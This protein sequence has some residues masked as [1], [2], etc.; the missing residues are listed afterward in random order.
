LKT[1]SQQKTIRRLLGILEGSF[2]KRAYLLQVLL[3]IGVVFESIG[4]GMIIPLVNVITDADTSKDNTFIR[5]IRSVTG[6]ISGQQLVFITLAGFVLF[7]LVKTIFLSFL[8]WKQTEFTQSLSRNISDRLFKG[9]IHQ[10]YVFF[11]DKNSGVLMKNI[12]A[13]VSSL[14]GY[15]Q[16]FMQLQTELSVLIG[17]VVT[18]FFLEP[19]GALVV[20]AFVGGISFLLVRVTKRR[21]TTWGKSRQQYDARRS[22][23]LLQGLTGVSELK[24]FRKENFFISRYTEANKYYY[25]LQRKSQFMQQVQRF[26]LEFI[27]IFSIVV[28]CFAIMLRGESIG[29]L[30]PSLSLFLFASLRMLP[31]ANRII[32]NL[33]AMRFTKA[34][35]DLVYEEFQTFSSENKAAGIEQN[36]A[37]TIRDSIQLDNISYIYP[38]GTKKALDSISFRIQAGSV[39]GIIGQSG[40]GKTTLVN[41]IVGLL[42]PS[43]G[44]LSIDG[45]DITDASHRL[46]KLTGYVPQN[47]FLLDDTLKR[48]IAF[49]IP[50]ELIDDERLLEVIEAAQLRQVVEGMEGGVEGVVGE[51][52]LKLS[53]GQRQ[54]IGIARALYH[55][56]ELLI[57]DEGTSALDAETESYIMESVA[58]LKGRLTILLIA[59]R[60]STL[61]ICDIVYKMQDGKIMAEG[62]LEEIVNI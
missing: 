23:S 33:Q 56:P 37:K 14:T 8:V 25:E 1:E 10:P 2:K 48:N 20:F 17:I 18:L 15:L 4:L 53:G 35:V 60:Y 57:L 50:D 47:I 21:V 26:Y 43:S 34:G 40:S 24:L 39:V 49:G 12:M 32:S 42:E 59:H 58:R 9:Y 27:L 13:E 62:K 7:Y 41:I 45:E 19:V 29:S 6:N 46:Q 61:H 55:R 51:R 44:K 3:L 54:R 38:A 52:G 36:G 30:L 5:L 31:S 11:L 28:L 16:A 22:K